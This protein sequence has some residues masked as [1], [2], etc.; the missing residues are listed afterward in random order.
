LKKRGL[1]NTTNLNATPQKYGYTRYFKFGS[2]GMSLNVRFDFWQRIAD[3]PFWLSIKDDTT[4]KYWVQTEA[5]KLLTKNLA[6]RLSILSYETRK[7]EM[8]LPI[9][10]LTEKTEDTVIDDMTNQIIKLANVQ[11]EG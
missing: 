10:P 3:T 7:R 1:A 2:L 8:Y 11:I 4:G 5:F 9:F 6:N